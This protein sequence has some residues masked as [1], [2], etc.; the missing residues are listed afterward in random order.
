MAHFPES[1]LDHTAKCEKDWG[2]GPKECK[3]EHHNASLACL[4]QRTH[5]YPPH[6]PLAAL[7][8]KLR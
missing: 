7:N 8:P 4:Q 6:I 3:L 5:V 2:L 1:C